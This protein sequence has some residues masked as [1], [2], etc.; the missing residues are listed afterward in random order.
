MALS[1]IATALKELLAET[2]VP[3]RRI[4]AVGISIPGPVDPHTKRPSQPPIMP[5]W[6]AFPVADVLTEALGAPVFVE[7]DA[8]VLVANRHTAV[9]AGTK[10]LMAS[11]H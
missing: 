4:G 6:D 2:P 3:R 11:F 8:A 10:R 1:S 5:G 7:N 9:P